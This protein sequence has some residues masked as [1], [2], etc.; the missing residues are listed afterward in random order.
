MLISA[1]FFFEVLYTSLLIAESA[2]SFAVKNV[3]LKI[4][5]LWKHLLFSKRKSAAPDPI[6][7]KNGQHQRVEDILQN[8]SF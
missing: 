4:Q 8:E 5:F 7:K 1:L 2:V 6:H 3:R